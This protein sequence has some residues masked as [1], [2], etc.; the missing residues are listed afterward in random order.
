MK[1]TCNCQVKCRLLG[2]LEQEIMEILWASPQ[3][4]KPAVVQQTLKNKYAYTTVMTVLNRLNNKKIV[5]RRVKGKAYYYSPCLKKEEF[6][7]SCLQDLFARLKLSY[8]SVFIKEAVDYLL[9]L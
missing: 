3:P 8:G 6:V 5:N 1:C 9:R 4:L 2:S 7:R